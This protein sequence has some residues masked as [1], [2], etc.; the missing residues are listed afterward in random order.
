MHLVR[1]VTGHKQ[2]ALVRRFGNLHCISLLAWA[3]LES[4]RLLAVGSRPEAS[5]A[6]CSD[7]PGAALQWLQWLQCC[8]RSSRSSRS[9]RQSQDI[10][11]QQ[12]HLL[13]AS[14]PA[15][16]VAERPASEGRAR[17]AP[18]LSRKALLGEGLSLQANVAHHQSVS[19]PSGEESSIMWEKA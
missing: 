4:A 19:V 11:S 18:K 13:V 5:E 17:V 14:E 15:L 7:W 10:L 6:G 9:S 3:S 1:P 8:S 16:Y 12:R 2:D